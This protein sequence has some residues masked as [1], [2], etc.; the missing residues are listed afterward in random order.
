LANPECFLAVLA[1]DKFLVSDGGR[2]LK[3]WSWPANGGS[4]DDNSSWSLRERV[5][6]PP[7]ILP[8]AAGK[9]AR[10]LV[11]D[12]TGSI[13]LFGLDRSDNL[14]RRWVPGVTAALPNGSVSPNFGLQT[15]AAGRTLAAYTVKAKQV[16]C[17]D[18]DADEPRWITP[19]SEESLVGSPVALGEGKWLITDLGGRV[20][21]LNA[22]TG[23]PIITREAGLAGAI[24][25]TAAVPLGAN[26]VL[27]PLSDGSAALIDLVEKK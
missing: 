24:P 9:P 10:M 11:A 4:A 14:I 18:L 20:S 27:I 1:S 12:S 23:Q 21:V 19:P 6:A 22:E 26:R 13:T 17:L 16:V 2:M 7:L 5:A 8:A 15:D 3:Q 25:E